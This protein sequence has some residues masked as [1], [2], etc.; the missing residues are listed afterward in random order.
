MS[1]PDDVLAQLAAGQ[2]D[3]R[4]MVQYEDLATVAALMERIGAY[5]DHLAER[6]T[7]V[8]RAYDALRLTVIPEMMD[9]QQLKSAN[10]DGVGRVTLTADAY[11]ACPAGMQPALQDWL[12]SHGFE[13]MIKE[14]VNSSTLKAWAVRRYKSGEEVPEFVKITPFTRA[15]ITKVSQA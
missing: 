5:L 1:I 14:T 6:K 2:A 15:S 10:I 7:N 9:A 4:D 11:V 13:D 12:T 8:Q 3:V